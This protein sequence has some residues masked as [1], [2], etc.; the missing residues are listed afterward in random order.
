[1]STEDTCSC[2]SEKCDYRALHDQEAAYMAEL[3]EKNVKWP[4]LIRGDL[5]IIVGTIPEWVVNNTPKGTIGVCFEE[6]GY[7]EPNSGPM[8]RFANGK[9][10]NVYEGWVEK[11]TAAPAV[12]EYDSL[13]DEAKLFTFQDWIATMKN[14]FNLYLAQWDGQNDYHKESHTWGQWLGTFIRYMSW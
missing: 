11:I 9:C 5:V 12:P 14:E 3:A 4:N 13:K 8:V 7:H 1:M 10:C 2:G 6:A